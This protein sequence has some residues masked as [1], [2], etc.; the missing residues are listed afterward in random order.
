MLFHVASIASWLAWE[1]VPDKLALYFPSEMFPFLLILQEFLTEALP[2]GLI[3][4]NCAL[5]KQYIEF[6]ADRLL[7]ELGF[8]KVKWFGKYINF[9]WSI[10]W[11]LCSCINWMPCLNSLAVCKENCVGG[12]S[13][14]GTSP[15]FGILEWDLR[16]LFH[17]RSPFLMPGNSWLPVLLYVLACKPGLTLISDVD[18]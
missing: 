2:V 6:V 1:T 14:W 18:F 8:S 10:Q 12:L 4:M 16:S 5:M 17:M 13:R 7:L 3:G 11:V 9:L 15:W